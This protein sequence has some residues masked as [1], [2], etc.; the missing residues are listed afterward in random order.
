MVVRAYDKSHRMMRT[1][2]QRTFVNQ[3]ISDIVT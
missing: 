3:T 2:K 1:R